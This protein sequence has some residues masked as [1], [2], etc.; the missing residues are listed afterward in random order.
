MRFEKI[1]SKLPEYLKDTR[2][3]LGTVLSQDGAPGLTE[4]QIAG[5]ALTCSSVLKD[6]SLFELF[7]EE[8][9]ELLNDQ[10]VI[11]SRLAANLMAMNN[12][13]YRAMHFAKDAEFQKRPAKLRMNAIANSGAE[14]ADF[15]LYSLAA[16][17]INGCELCVRSHI[18]SA[19]KH[20]LTEDAIHSALRVAAVIN[21][22]HHGIN[23]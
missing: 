5:I 23:I 12:I 18:Q 9:K 3:N 7:L 1:K 19:K 22:T 8:F 17:A 6:N 15:E 10:E 21:A 20:G 14:K 11:A 16:S 13:Y 2:L 4:K